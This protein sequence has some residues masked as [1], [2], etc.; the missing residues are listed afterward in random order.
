MPRDTGRCTTKDFIYITTHP[1]QLICFVAV[2]V[3]IVVAFVTVMVGSTQLPFPF[4]FQF[5]TCN[6]RNIG[7][8]GIHLLTQHATREHEENNGT[9]EQSK[10]ACL[11]EIIASLIFIGNSTIVIVVVKCS[12]ISRDIIHIVVVVMIV[13]VSDVGTSNGTSE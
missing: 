13:R 8:N 9:Q 7:R 12:Q 6:F 10:R 1:A 4:P 2:V 5:H 3:I 11:K